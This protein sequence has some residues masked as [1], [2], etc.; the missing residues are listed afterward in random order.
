MIAAIDPLL[1]LY[2]TVSRWALLVACCALGP[3]V[4]GAGIAGAVAGLGTRGWGLAGIALGVAQL[5]HGPA[6]LRLELTGIILHY[7]V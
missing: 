4:V 2:L 7:T 6:G 1:R 3:S 5:G